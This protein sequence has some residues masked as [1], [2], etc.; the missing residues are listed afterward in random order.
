MRKDKTL[1][2]RGIEHEAVDAG[3]AARADACRVVWGSERLTSNAATW[4][5]G[6]RTTWRDGRGARLH[7]LVFLWYLYI[8]KWQE[9]FLAIEIRPVCLRITDCQWDTHGQQYGTFMN[10]IA[11]VFTL[12]IFNELLNRF[13]PF[14][15]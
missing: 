8:L 7:A 4:H 14:W 9:K 13:L 3:V 6:D 1:T 10:L 2:K 12:I 15:L 5:G 11:Q